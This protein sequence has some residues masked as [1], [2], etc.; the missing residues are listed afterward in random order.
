MA[1][2]GM[3]IKWLGAIICRVIVDGKWFWF[4]WLRCLHA[5]A[6]MY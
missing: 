2:E 3:P 5:E 6:E 1:K 4:L